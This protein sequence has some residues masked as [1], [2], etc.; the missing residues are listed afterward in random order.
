M[1][2]FQGV[3]TTLHEPRPRS[4]WLHGSSLMRGSASDRFATTTTASSSS[5]GPLLCRSIFFGREVCG[6]SSHC[7]ALLASALLPCLPPWWYPS[8]EGLCFHDS[9]H[10]ALESRRYLCIRRKGNVRP[11]FGC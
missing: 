4:S 3:Q 8:F 9:D 10:C 1:A 7:S 11:A 5:R 6:L 2:D